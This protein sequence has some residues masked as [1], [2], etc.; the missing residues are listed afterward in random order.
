MLAAIPPTAFKF[1]MWAMK[2]FQIYNY[3][4]RIA[5]S[6]CRA[7]VGSRTAWPEVEPGKPPAGQVME[8]ALSLFEAAPRIA[9]VLQEVEARAEQGKEQKEAANEVP[10][11]LVPSTL[12]PKVSR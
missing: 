1:C 6:H 7:A 2:S 5:G 10:K 11:E 4:R 12:V 9:A 3:G 8:T